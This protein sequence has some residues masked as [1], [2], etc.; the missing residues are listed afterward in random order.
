MLENVIC[1]VYRLSKIWL[2]YPQTVLP[3]SPGEPSVPFV[4]PQLQTVRPH[5]PDSTIQGYHSPYF[6][7]FLFFYIKKIYFKKDVRRPIVFLKQVLASDLGHCTILKSTQYTTELNCTIVTVVTHNKALN[8]C[9]QMHCTTLYCMLYNHHILSRHNV[10]GTY[11]VHCKDAAQCKLLTYLQNSTF[12]SC[13][14]H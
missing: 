5:L 8:H 4:S 10:P 2:T 1:C 3:G 11:Q 9:T 12:P 6:E 13:R 14:V 7:K